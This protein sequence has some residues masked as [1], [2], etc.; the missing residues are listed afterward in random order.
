MKTLSTLI[1]I[2][3]ATFCWGQSKKVERPKHFYYY[4]SAITQSGKTLNCMTDISEEATEQ[5]AKVVITENMTIC[6]SSQ[7]YIMSISSVTK[8]MHDNWKKLVKVA[9]HNDKSK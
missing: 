3:L 1:L 5:I 7:V 9:Y 2:S 6:D 8:S 4:I